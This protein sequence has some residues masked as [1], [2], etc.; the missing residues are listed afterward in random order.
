MAITFLNDA[1]GG[2]YLLDRNLYV[3]GIDYNR[4]YTGVDA[5]LLSTGDTS[6]TTVGGGTPVA[7]PTPLV[8]TPPGTF[9]YVGVN[10]SGLEFGGAT[11]PGTLN[12]DYVEPTHAE[13]DYYAS[14]GM[15]I[16][17]LPFDWER[18]Q[19]VQN[20]P[21]DQ[22]YLA[23]MD[24]IVKYA[25]SKGLK[26]DLDMH[27]YGQYYG[28]A[29]GS[30]STPNSS[31]D[32]VWSQLAS[33]YAGSSN[34]LY[35]LMNEPYE[36]T[37]PQW[38]TSVNGAIGA[39]RA[40]GATQEIL[41]SGTHVDGGSSWT[42]TDNASVMAGVTDPD[43]NFAFEIHQYLDAD[44]SGTSTSVVSPTIG[45][46]RLTAV[47]QWAQATGN[48]LLLTEFGSGSDSASL[49]ATAN[50][51]NYMAQNTNVWQGRHGVG[52]RPVVGQL[53]LRDG[54]DERRRHQADRPAAELHAHIRRPT[55]SG[56]PQPNRRLRQVGAYVWQVGAERLTQSGRF[57]V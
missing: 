16:I 53:R 37:A 44:G 14:K 11:Y 27:N 48:H 38:L 20:G 47:T 9:Q 3:S 32:N 33:H 54:P 25:G 39:I 34:V 49:T 26:V 1:N 51:L 17:R 46:E 45:V 18:L 57:G 13:I 7:P 29:I 55:S 31:F 2:S 23:L 5:T 15:N 28:D 8:V 30:S 4:V 12:T 24:D 52:R 41:V 43:M 50:M 42:T 22:K 56:R 10:L 19:P 6:T 21:L 35:G 36:Q 40:A